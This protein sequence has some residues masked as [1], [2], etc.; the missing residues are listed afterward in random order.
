MICFVVE[1]GTDR[2][3]KEGIRH[4]VGAWQETVL[5]ETTGT[6]RHFRGNMET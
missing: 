3:G 5:R 6:G 2:M 4:G 1:L